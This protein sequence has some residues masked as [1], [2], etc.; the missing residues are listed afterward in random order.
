MEENL[1]T[2][3]PLT[4]TTYFILLSLSP[5]PCHGYSIMKEV[6]Q[7]SRGRVL[8]S[9]G[10]L[11]SALKRLLDLGWI[12]RSGDPQV[13]E[14]GRG[15]KTYRLSGLGSQILENEILRLKTLVSAANL[16]AVGDRT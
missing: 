1:S 8:L 15:R 4:E 14:D 12:E 10:T 9:T 7:L 5:G 6:R 16:R 2:N 3:F 13:Q 11:Y